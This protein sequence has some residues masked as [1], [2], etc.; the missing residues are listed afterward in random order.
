MSS[1]INRQRLLERFL[2][3]VRVDTTAVD[4]A[5][6]YPSSPGQLEL[7]KMI[8]DELREMG[9]AEVEQNEFGIVMAT[10][11]GTS[12]GE[13]PPVIAFNS[14]LDT[15]PET[16]GRNVQPRVIENYAGGDIPLGDT[17]LTIL[18]SESPELRNLHGATLITTDGTTLLGGDDKAGVA[19]ILELAQ[20][21]LENPQIPH[22]E[23]RVLLT[24]DEEIGRGVD[25]VDVDRVAATACYTLD[26]AAAGEIDVETFSADQATI[27]VTGKNIHPAIAKG[28]MIN[29]LRVTASLLGRL[30]LDQ[31]PETTADR[32]GFLHPYTMS[33]GVAEVNLKVLLRAFDTA[34]LDDFAQLLRTAAQATEAEFPGARID[35][36][37]KRQ[38]R[39]LGDGLKQEPRAVAFVEQAY[40]RLGRSYRKTIVRGGTDGS[41]FTALGLPTPNLSTGQHKIHSPLEWACLDE[42]Q[43]ACELCVEIC[44]VWAGG[45]R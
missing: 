35:V 2:R 27:T 19:V 22:G 44:Q 8:A 23:I 4:D 37:I 29:A 20:H 36:D 28:A 26:G 45:Q 41:M 7:G 17:G 16:T 5:G 18:E 15:S 31:A 40:E 33:G 6:V 32:Q 42:M 39:N 34:T 38:Y 25:H 30:P 43:Q 1:S 12:Q 24:C 3:Y 14:H 21:L 11:P 9:A 13:P 10:V